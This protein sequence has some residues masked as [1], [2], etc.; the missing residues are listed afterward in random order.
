MRRHRNPSAAA[1]TRAAVPAAD[2]IQV[3]MMDRYFVPRRFRVDCDGWPAALAMI[4]AY[5]HITHAIKIGRGYVTLY[6]PDAAAQLRHWQRRQT[7]ER[8]EL[9]AKH[10]QHAAA[11]LDGWYTIL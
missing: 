6:G 10:P 4:A 1:R 11:I 8:A 3:S 9:A 7:A 2:A 5:A